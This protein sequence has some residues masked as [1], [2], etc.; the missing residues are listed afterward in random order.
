MANV[1]SSTSMKRKALPQMNKAELK[2]M[3]RA[4]EISF[5]P[6][7]TNATLVSRIEESGK[8]NPTV[9]KG[10]SNVKVENG[11]RIHPSLGKYRKVIVHTRDPKEGS[12]FASI[13]L[14][15]VEFQPEEKIELP[16]GMI[17]FLKQAHY[18]EHYYDPQAISENGNI[19]AHLT[20][21]VPRYIVERVDEEDDE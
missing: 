16:I 17:K 21:K 7:D 11:I 15:T 13:N 9:E 2:E 8:Y 5:E 14:Y 6:S 4:L 18:L 10:V 20:R 3:C 19:G 12:I 1:V